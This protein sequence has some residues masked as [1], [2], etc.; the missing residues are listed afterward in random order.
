[1]DYVFNIPFA[2]TE[3]EEAGHHLCHAALVTV[4]AVIVEAAAQFVVVPQLSRIGLVCHHVW[5]GAGHYLGAGVHQNLNLLWNQSLHE[6]R[7]KTDQGHHLEAR[8]ERKAWSHMEMAP[9]TRVRD[10]M[11]GHDGLG[12]L[13]TFGGLETIFELRLLCNLDGIYGC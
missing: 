1:M 4:L 2:G 7:A 5:R 6:G 8:M 12:E 9:Q 13:L 10:E 11:C 3:A